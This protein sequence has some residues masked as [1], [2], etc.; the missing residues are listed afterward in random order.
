MKFLIW[1][2]NV[3]WARHFFIFVTMAI[4]LLC[5]YIYVI[6]FGAEALNLS[7]AGFYG[8]IAVF[9]LHFIW[10][11]TSAVIHFIQ[12]EWK[13]AIMKSILGVAYI[14]FIFFIF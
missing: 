14:F 3:T 12:K 7:L 4:V 1:L 9:V 2:R 11:T 6:I 13:P 5:L 8:I 10:I